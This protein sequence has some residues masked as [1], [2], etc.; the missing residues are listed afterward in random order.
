VL[1]GTY[2][3]SAGFYDA[4]YI[5]ALKVRRRIADDFD[6]AGAVRRPADAVHAQR[7]LRA[8][9]K[10]ADPVTM[11]LNDVFTVPAQPGRPA[12]HQRARRGWTATA[13]R[14]AAAG[15]TRARR[16]HA[17]L[18]GRRPGAGGRLPREA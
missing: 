11:Y 16:R 13:C 15:R 17:V 1:I 9:D 14:W 2:V 6:Q 4:Y 12:G 10:A 8:G 5:R 7:R 3:L 18:S